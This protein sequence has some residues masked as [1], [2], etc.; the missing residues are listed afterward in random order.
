MYSEINYCLSIPGAIMQSE[1]GG[2]SLDSQSSLQFGKIPGL[3][4]AQ[5]SPSGHVSERSIIRL[6]N[7]LDNKLSP[8]PQLD[9][10]ASRQTVRSID[11]KANMFELYQIF[12]F[13]FLHSDRIRAYNAMTKVRQTVRAHFIEKIEISDTV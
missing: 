6:I 1:K 3:G 7:Q 9:T 5:V 8:E 13:I 10:A 2:L 12:L 11:M 4:Q